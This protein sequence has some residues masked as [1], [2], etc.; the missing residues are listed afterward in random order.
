MIA[1]WKIKRE[2]ARFRQQLRAIPEYFWEPIANQRHNTAMARGFPTTQGAQG[3]APKI[4]IIL[5]YQ[6]GGLA[7]SIGVLCC[8]LAKTGHA[9]LIV[10]NT[11][12]AD[13][14]RATLAGMVWRIIERPNFG[15]DFGGYRDGLWHLSHWG[16]V[17]Q[18]LVIMNDS[19]WFP[20][21]DS[22]NTLARMEAMDVDVAGTVLR[23]RGAARF[24][25]SYLF[26]IRGS[27]LTHPEFRA[28]W[29]EFSLTSNKYKVIRRGERGFGTALVAAGLTI[30]GLF[31]RRDFDAAIA[32]ASDADLRLFLQFTAH[33]DPQ[34]AKEGAALAQ[35]TD[36]NDW[37][38]RAKAYIERV[39]AKG[40]FYSSFPVAAV[41]LLDYPIMKKSAEPISAGWRR[42][43]V[44]A[45]KNGILQKPMH[46]I[47]DEMVRLELVTEDGTT[48]DLE[49]K[50]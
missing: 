28:F 43:Y 46:P 49:S 45:V 2:A 31:T 11:I 9:I 25:E 32:R 24:L 39:L 7:A 30:G 37:K 13:E 35:Q 17:P 8:H 38:D 15:Y 40:L 16:I 47:L 18:R 27:V 19:I 41:K 26:S 4:A 42:S 3:L 23:E 48:T 44:T 50:A 29:R 14:D 5:L 20:L 22:D 21:H 34:I 1:Q 33:Q 36:C 12:L 10:S 6:P